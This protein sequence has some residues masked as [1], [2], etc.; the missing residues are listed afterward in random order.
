MRGRPLMPCS[1]RKARLLLRENKA[2]IYKYHPFTI[3]LTYTTGE[4][5][6]DCHI[7][8]DTGSKYIG[9]AVRSEDKVF[10]K[11]EIELRQD[12]R[13]NLDTKRIYRRSRRNRKT[14][15]RKPRFLNRKR[16]DEWLPPSL[17]SRINHTFHWIDTLSSLVP[18]PILH[19]NYLSHAVQKFLWKWLLTVVTITHL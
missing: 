6:Q 14:R 2:M 10:W 8:I 19:V 7:G 13:S 16:R 1:Q 5:K 4:T 12:I 15:Y 11:G 17:Q 18:N 9:A 3:Q